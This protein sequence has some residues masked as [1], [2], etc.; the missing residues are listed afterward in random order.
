MRQP[1][2]HLA[3]GLIEP[4]KDLAQKYQTVT[5]ITKDGKK[6]VGVALDEDSFSLQM[7]GMDQRLHLF[8]KSD[9]REVLHGSKSLMP[10]YPPAMLSDKDLQDLVAYLAGLRGER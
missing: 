7:M 6:I 3:E 2:A 10:A 1:S 8:E 9:V 4:N 5:V